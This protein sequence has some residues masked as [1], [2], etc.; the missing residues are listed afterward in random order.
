MRVTLVR[1]LLLAVLA[2]VLAP[3][4]ALL[5]VP[6]PAGAEAPARLDGQVTDNAGALS[7][8]A[9][10][11]QPALSKLQTDTGIQLLVVFVRSFDGTPAQDWTDETARLSDLGDRDA[12]LAVATDDR[13]YAYSFP[14]DSRLTDA[15]LTRVAD[16]D[17]EPALA[18]GDWAGAVV[19]AADGYRDAMPAP[20]AHW[21]G[22]SWSSWWSSSPP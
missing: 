1:R 9:G 12:L 21:S 5:L 11:V 19:A 6:A 22:C 15:E 20:A 16:D 14:E 18:R 7:G 3:A 2:L 10:S 4:L 17:I 8:G 13:A